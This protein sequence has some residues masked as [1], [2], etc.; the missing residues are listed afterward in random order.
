MTTIVNVPDAVIKR[1]ILEFIGPN[2]DEALTTFAKDQIFSNTEWERAGMQATTKLART[3]SLFKGNSY[4]ELLRKNGISLKSLPLIR[5]E[6]GR[7]DV[8]YFDPVKM[9]HSIMLFKD[10]SARQ[11]IALKIRSRE[12]G[13]VSS[14]LFYREKNGEYG[15]LCIG[16]LY[17]AGKEKLF[18][19]LLNGQD[20]SYEIAG[21]LP[22]RRPPPSVSLSHRCKTAFAG[23]INFFAR[24]AMTPMSVHLPL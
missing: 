12:T 1:E 24:A 15:I 5:M 19:R 7:R 23:V 22:E 6:F 9:T 8:Q 18:E 3:L 17:A 14:M 2:S 11:G 13:M 16:M 20:P 10:P 21:T 4:A